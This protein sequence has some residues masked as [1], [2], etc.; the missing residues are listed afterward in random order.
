MNRLR[1]GNFSLF[2]S[3]AH[4]VPGVPDMFILL[5]WLVAGV[6]LG[7]LVSMILTLVLGKTAGMEYTMLVT[8]P[9]QFL[10][11]M[12]Y[13][14]YKSRGNAFNTGGFALD[15]KNFAPVGG[16]VC[17][18]WAITGTAAAGFASDAFT[19]ILPPVPEWLLNVLSSLTGGNILVDFICVSIMAP[20]FEEWL[21]R[22]MVL[23]GLLN[24]SGIKP[25]WAIVISAAFFALIHLNPW[26]AV[27]AFLLGCLFGYVYYRT[28]S[29]KLTMLMHFT[30][31]TIALVAANVP[32]WKD[33]DG[34]A[35]IMGQKMYWMY[36]VLALVIVAQSV[37]VYRK[38]KTKSKKGN[39]E[40]VE[41]IFQ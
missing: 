29:L 25:A 4:Y 26:Q 19:M 22:G 12:M 33:A 41:A 13:A 35:D 15:S 11:A 9:L 30:N 40:P 28:G 34:W 6:L 8:Y 39:C 23:R 27:P 36:F 10:P 21:C 38:I 2:G 31:N 17:A 20:F 32:A 18:L 5:A 1:R 14:S 7:S 3:Q 37:L 24:R 16:L